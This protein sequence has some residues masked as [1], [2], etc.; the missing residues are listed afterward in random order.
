MDDAGTRLLDALTAL[1][2]VAD[3]LTPAAARTAISTA[4]LQVFWR[5]WPNVSSWAG[6]LWRVLDDDLAEPA[7]M[8]VDPELDEVGE[9]DAG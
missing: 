3:A 8:Q 2:E 6:A 7:S 5:D 9:S 1:E 4:D